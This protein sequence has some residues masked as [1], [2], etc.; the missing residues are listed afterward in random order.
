[1]SVLQSADADDFANPSNDLSDSIA[2]VV[3]ALREF[4]ADLSIFVED[5]LAV[6]KEALN[7]CSQLW[8]S[9]KEAAAEIGAAIRVRYYD[10]SPS[11][12]RVKWPK[13]GGND[14]VY[15]LPQVNSHAMRCWFRT[16]KY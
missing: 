13:Y 6:F 8:A 5:C 7:V 14:F 1:M 2:S 11:S 10:V 16:Y 4:G 9:L 12:Q 15:K 3:A